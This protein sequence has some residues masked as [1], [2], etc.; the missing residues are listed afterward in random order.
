MTIEDD[1]STIRSQYDASIIILK[2]VVRLL[3][4]LKLDAVESYPGDDIT[5]TVSRR[6]G[7][8]QNLLIRAFSFIKGGELGEEDN[9]S[10]TS[11]TSKVRAFD[12]CRF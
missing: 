1:D 3:D 12:S 2:S 9:A 5:H 4:H 8:F 11:S 6:F 7:R 10:L